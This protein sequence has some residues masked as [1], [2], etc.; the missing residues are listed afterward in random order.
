[1]AVD[2]AWCPQGLC[3]AVSALLAMLYIAVGCA[4]PSL[5]QTVCTLSLF[6]FFVCPVTCSQPGPTLM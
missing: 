3:G 2:D 1:M 6:F 5:L 4:S